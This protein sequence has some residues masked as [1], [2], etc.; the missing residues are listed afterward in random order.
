M[1]QPRRQKPIMLHPVAWGGQSAGDV[2]CCEQYD[3]VPPMKQTLL[4]HWSLAVQLAPNGSPPPSPGTPSGAA[5]MPPEPPAP[6]APPEPP[7]P[8]EPPAP[9]PP[10]A[11]LL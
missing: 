7:P 5:S 1:G 10:P 3:C 2:Q 6:P 11:P 8:P 4:A 9:P